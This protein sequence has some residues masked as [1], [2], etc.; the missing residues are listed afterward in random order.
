M[1]EF[2]GQLRVWFL[3]IVIF[4]P[5]I[6][7][8]PAPLSWE[9]FRYKEITLRVDLTNGGPEKKNIFP[10]PHRIESLGKSIFSSW[11]GIETADMP[12]YLDI[13]NTSTVIYSGNKIAD[14][15]RFLNEGGMADIYI[16]LNEDG[17]DV[18]LKIPLASS[19]RQSIAALRESGLGNQIVWQVKPTQKLE[20]VLFSMSVK[21]GFE[22]KL[23]T[24][25][26][27]YLLL[28]GG[29]VILLASFIQV[30]HTLRRNRND[31]IYFMDNTD[32]K[33][34]EYLTEKDVASEAAV[35]NE[36]FKGFDISKEE[37]VQRL[38]TLQTKGFV[39]YERPFGNGAF[40][41][42]TE[43]GR[44]A[45]KTFPRKVQEYLTKHFLEI[46][47]FIAAVLTLW[48]TLN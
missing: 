12:T 4:A 38:K 18:A 34:L 43:D 23:A 24:Y 25:V 44:H 37:Y 48:V 36:T 28:F 3:I 42:I 22:F 6:L 35:I 5:A 8:F 15:K 26:K 13:V 1:K 20:N 30:F 46:L 33:I 19:T 9:P 7:A 31:G 10:V 21:I 41:Y 40:V 45:V 27:N 39:R 47:I 2:I 32:K 17:V 14:P 11:L 29:W 16:N